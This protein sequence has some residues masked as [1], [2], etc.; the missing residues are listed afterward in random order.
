M[1]LFGLIVTLGLAS[2]TAIQR[3]AKMTCGDV[4]KV[5]D[6][7]LPASVPVS[8][9]FGGA[10]MLVRADDLVKNKEKTKALDCSEISKVLDWQAFVVGIPP[11]SASGETIIM[12]KIS[13]QTLTEALF[14]KAGSRHVW[15]IWNCSDPTGEDGGKDEMYG[16]DIPLSGMRLL[17]V[18][19]TY[20]KWGQG[21]EFEWVGA[22]DSWAI[23][24]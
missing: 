12:G 21:I 3:P 4:K 8:E 17:S 13:N 18:H 20:D 1:N 7:L 6:M 15:R 23:Y 24:P 5:L 16:V 9:L 11:E 2:A 10:T 19:D 14:A 22:A